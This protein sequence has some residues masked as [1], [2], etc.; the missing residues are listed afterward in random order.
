M[1][2]PRNV[3]YLVGLHA[4]DLRALVENEMGGDVLACNLKPEGFA[5]PDERHVASDVPACSNQLT[6]QPGALHAQMDRS[7][8]ANA[9]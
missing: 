8:A 2:I 6:R 3:A 1:E 5:P 7:L 9:A 4:A